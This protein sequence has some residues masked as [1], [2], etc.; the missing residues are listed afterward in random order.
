ML[1]QVEQRFVC[2]MTTDS[3]RAIITETHNCLEIQH[4]RD[5]AVPIRTTFTF[6]RS[7]SSQEE[8]CF[9]KQ[10]WDR[11]LGEALVCPDSRDADHRKWRAVNV[12]VSTEFRPNHPFTAD[13]PGFITSAR[14][15]VYMCPSLA[16]CRVTISWAAV[17]KTALSRT[18]QCLFRSRA[19][20]T[21]EDY[22]KLPNVLIMY[23]CING[24]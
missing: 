14:N 7:G 8:P 3:T 16:L 15:R 5:T 1:F 19:P 21:P 2:H 13:T 24:V 4:F 20:P 22:Q 10:G 6:Y 23:S 9:C 17:L 11:Y 18:C 12:R